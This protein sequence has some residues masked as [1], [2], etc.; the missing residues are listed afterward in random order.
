MSDKKNQEELEKFRKAGKLTARVREEIRELVEPGKDLLFIAEKVEDLIREKGAKPAFPCNISLNE[1]A[2]HYSPPADDETKIEEGDLVTIDIGA[3]LDG[4]IGDTAMTIATNEKDQQMVETAELALDKAIEGIKPSIN[5]GE[6]G[7]IIEN[8]IEEAGFKPIRNLSGHSMD[9]W[10]LHSGTTIP[11]I[12]EKSEKNLEEGEIV[13]LE[14]FVTDGAG[15]VKSQPEA[16]IFLYLNDEAVSGR[17]ALKTLRLIKQKYGKLPFAE[18]WLAEDMSKIRL[19]MT[20]RELIT[21]RSIYPY[22]VLKEKENGK[23]AQAEHTVIVTDEGC[24]I[25]TL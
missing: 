13:A 14:P 5:V 25:T 8:T 18:R 9:R 15:E 10:S 20:L 4:Y 7:G 11:N 21:S 3:H 17:M 24:E 12:K 16:Y 2:A 22:Y 1:A 6:I 19:Q 23:V